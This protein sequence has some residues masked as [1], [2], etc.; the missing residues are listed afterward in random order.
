MR[1]RKCCAMC[2]A[3]LRRRHLVWTNGAGLICANAH[4]CVMWRQHVAAWRREVM[5]TL[6]KPTGSGSY[7]L[8][9]NC[10]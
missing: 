2:G 9:G 1:R 10:E 3:L 4:T 7:A 6:P 5:S 8:E